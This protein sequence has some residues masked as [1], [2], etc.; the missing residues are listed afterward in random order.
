MIVLSAI[1]ITYSYQSKSYVA[2]EHISE[3]QQNLRAAM[4]MLSRDLRMAGYDPFPRHD[5]LNDGLDNDCDGG[6][7]DEPGELIGILEADPDSIT[8]NMS[9]YDGV[10]NDSDGDTDEL[11][12]AGEIDVALA[13]ESG[14]E[15]CDKKEIISYSRFLSSSGSY[16]L[17]RKIGRPEDKNE[18]YQ[19]VAENIEA[20]NFVYL[21]E[22]RNVIDDWKGSVSENRDQIR[23]IQV[24]M[25]ARSRKEEAK[26]INHSEYKNLQGQVVFKSPGDHFR[27]LVKSVE[28][29]C[30]N[31]GIS[32]HFAAIQ[33]P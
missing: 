7:P 22:D 21:D 30:R 28:I 18:K 5:K 24:T 11:D 3:M 16:C 26:I 23:L 32:Q 20:L 1:Y 10:D 25:V 19:P 29:R 6:A 9:L 15:P 14:L 13:S 4:Y 8:F 33:N 12:E 31:L 27:R 2:Q 17:G